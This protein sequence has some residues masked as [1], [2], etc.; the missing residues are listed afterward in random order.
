MEFKS[1]FIE[2]TDI[3]NLQC[4]TC[5]NWTSSYGLAFEDITSILDRAGKGGIRQLSLTGGEP[6]LHKNIYDIISY[7]HKL[8]MHTNMLQ[9]NTYRSECC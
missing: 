6:L 2:L 5:D 4:K 9:W 1:L 8:R 7:A 3:C